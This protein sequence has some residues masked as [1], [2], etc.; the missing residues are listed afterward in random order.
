MLMHLTPCGRLAWAEVTALIG[1]QPCAWADLDGF[2][3]GPAPPQPPAYTHLWAW[4]PRRWVRVRIDGQTGIAGVLSL[5]P[6]GEPVDV[7]AQHGH[8][9]RPVE[10]QRIPPL[11]AVVQQRSWTLLVV[12]GLAPVTFVHGD[13]WPSGLQHDPTAH[14]HNRPDAP[15]SE[16]G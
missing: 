12:A 10:D 7:H 2:H 11:P 1:G 13:T 14:D 6:P 5:D 9:W 4:S 16:P 3:V 8:L 15:V